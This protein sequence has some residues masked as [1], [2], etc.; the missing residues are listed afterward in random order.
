MCPL[1]KCVT[2]ETTA[3][4][5]EHIMEV[6]GEDAPYPDVVG[7]QRKLRFAL[8]LVLFT[9]VLAELLMIL[10]NYVTPVDYPWSAITG[11]GL[12][13]IYISLKYWV[14]HDSGFASKVGLQIT[15]T[16]CLLFAI[17]NCTGMRGWA[18]QWAIPGVVLLGDIIVAVLMLVNRSRWQSYLLLLVFMAVIAFVLIVLYFAGQIESVVLPLIS[19]VV[20]CFYLF[21]MILFGGRKATH[22]FSRRFHI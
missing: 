16:I 6:F 2:Q 14:S 13:Y 5:K 18:L 9:F 10:I 19:E 8:K 17:D 12:I 7:R 3:A 1:C 21:V 20:T 4:E 15:I 22:E 11:I